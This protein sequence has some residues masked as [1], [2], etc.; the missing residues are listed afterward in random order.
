[1][2]SRARIRPGMQPIIPR[3]ALGG[4][5]RS[6]RSDRPQLGWHLDPVDHGVVW[7]RSP[8]YKRHI[9]KDYCPVSPGP[10]RATQTSSMVAGST[11]D[12]C[13]V[14][15]RHIVIHWATGTRRQHPE[16]RASGSLPPER[17]GQY[18]R[19]PAAERRCTAPS[20]STSGG[21]R[22][23]RGCG[24]ECTARRRLSG[25][26]PWYPRARIMQGKPPNIFLVG[27]MG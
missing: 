24:A 5:S 25:R 1:M 2:G 14:S 16:Q 20:R 8:A 13:G 26:L 4:S 18:Q 6:I 12:I 11:C 9:P 19:R 21:R 22:R 15:E 3:A 7:C 27:P 10:M 23:V 17:H